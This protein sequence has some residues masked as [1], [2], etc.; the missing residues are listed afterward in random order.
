MINTGNRLLGCEAEFKIKGKPFSSVSRSL[1][2]ILVLASP[3]PSLGLGL[4][5]IIN[6]GTGSLQD[7]MSN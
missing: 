4:K 1:P 6:D 5:W 7:A 2:S 3:S